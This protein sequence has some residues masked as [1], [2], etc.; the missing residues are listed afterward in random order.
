MKYL[1]Y[2]VVF[3]GMAGAAYA[4]SPFDRPADVFSCRFPVPQNNELYANGFKPIMAVDLNGG[5]K[6]RIW[7]S[8]SRWAEQVVQGRRSCVVDGGTV[9]NS[10]GLDQVQ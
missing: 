4:L 9:I 6:W 5:G 7:V 2:A 1:L 10:L 8:S 3:I